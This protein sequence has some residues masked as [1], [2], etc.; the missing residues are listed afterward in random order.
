MFHSPLGPWRA[1]M[2]EGQSSPQFHLRSAGTA[3][4]SQV[5]LG[6]WERKKAGLKSDFIWL[7]CRAALWPLFTPSSKKTENKNNSILRLFR[8]SNNNKLSFFELNTFFDQKLFT[9][10]FKRHF[11]RPL[12]VLWA[13][14]ILPSVSNGWVSPASICLRQKSARLSLLWKERQVTGQEEFRGGDGGAGRKCA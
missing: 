7:R 6:S 3:L 13:L 12:K 1:H 11:C 2:R 8:Y 5:P 9:S 4:F 14:G 10:D